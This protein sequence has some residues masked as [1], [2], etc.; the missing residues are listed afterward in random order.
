MKVFLSYHFADE[1]FVR[2]TAFYLKQQS[3][4]TPYFYGDVSSAEWI[5]EVS[6]RLADAGAFFLF[7]GEQLGETQKLEVKGA[8]KSGKQQI[9]VVKLPDVVVPDELALVIGFPTIEVNDL[10][11]RGAQ[12]CAETLTRSLDMPWVPVHDL[13]S[14]YIFEYEKDI[15][16]A[17]SK[18]TIAPELISRGCPTSW[19]SIERRE[20]KRQSPLREDVGLFRDW[21]YR[22]NSFKTEESMVLAGALKDLSNQ[23]I[24][25]RLYFPEA[26]PRKRLSY[27]ARPGPLTVGVLVSGGIAPG[28]NAV[29]AGIVERQALYAEEGGYA[30]T[31]K[32]YQNGLNAIYARGDHSRPLTKADVEARADQGGSILGTSRLKDFVSPDPLE[33]RNALERAMRHLSAHGVEILYII[34]GDGSMRAAHALWRT[35][36]D[37]QRN[38]SI[39]GVPKTMDNDVLWVWQSFGFLSAVQRSRDLI[40]ELHTEA[41]SN[42]RL[43]VIQ[44]FGSDSG[45]VVTHAV[46]AIDVCDLF[47][48]PEVPFAMSQVCRYI[49]GRLRQR[50]DQRA[51][52]ETTHG[53]IVMAETAIPR[54]ARDY[55]DDPEVDLTNGE[56]TAIST[57]LESGRVFGQTPDELRS[58]GLKLVSRVIQKYIKE[59]VELLP[60]AYWRE[61]R[62]FINEPRHQIR[63]TKPSSSDTIT[64]KR[65][66]TLAVD[67]AMAGYDDFMISQWLTE[68]VMVPLRLVV[69]GRK[70]IPRYGVFYKSAIASTG[71]P[72]NLV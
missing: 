52:L 49:C 28:I 70:R 36:R 37:Q 34:G 30:L 21:D 57:F 2:S 32:G 25:N 42:P 43:C 16:S 10:D 18:E 6:K 68:Y 64:A 4:L 45:F 55:F 65:L 47:L 3:G 19:P 13:P 56:K 29:I 23:L 17:Y 44:L 54:D 27:P 50:F 5:D 62:V 14:E 8:I 35:A 41:K 11:E 22:N 9:R 51:S 7:I 61:F 33:R 39:V 31:I 72:A 53:M 12:Q 1:P 24:A 26:G 15:I 63:A 66:G 38:I 67:G 71:Q 20:F 40:E 59:N 46:S 58:G 60:E 48:I 69:L